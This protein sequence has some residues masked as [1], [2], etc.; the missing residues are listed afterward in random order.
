MTATST[1]ALRRVTV[2]VTLPVAA[3]LVLTGCS[4]DGDG[5]R[6][7]SAMSSAPAAVDSAAAGSAVRATTNTDALDA[8]GRIAV[9]AV[10]GGTVIA[11]EQEARDSSWEV[12]VAA[13]DGTAQQVRTNGEGTDVTAGPTPDDTDHD[14]VA[15]NRAILQAATL[16]FR[17]A[18]SV[19]A[20]TVPGAISEL[21]LD[22][23]AGRAVWQGS[24]LDARG[25]EHT[26]RV[27]AGSGDVM[28]NAVDT[29]D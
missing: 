9:D 28:A 14:D 19:L 20:S 5:D 24:V 1:S 2:I 3:A 16:T 21:G 22:D 13:D 17:D 26:I 23:D 15:E 18:A 12:L 27:D 11:I 6:A 7:A 4:R 8:A 29:D 10:G 25:A